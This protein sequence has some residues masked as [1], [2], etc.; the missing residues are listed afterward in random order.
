[1]TEREKMTRRKRGTMQLSSLMEL[2]IRS[3]GVRHVSEPPG[4]SVKIISIQLVY[5]T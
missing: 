2:Q 5:Y 1:M 3:L 4:A